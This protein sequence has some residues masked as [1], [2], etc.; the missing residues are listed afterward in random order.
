MKLQTKKHLHLFCLL[1]RWLVIELEFP[2][3]SKEYLPNMKRKYYENLEEITE[4]AKDEKITFDQ[5][6]IHVKM[7]LSWRTKSKNTS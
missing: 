1:E 7:L 5:F 4:M 6:N 3:S 2:N